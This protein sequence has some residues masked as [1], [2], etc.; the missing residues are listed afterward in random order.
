[1]AQLF[2][3]QDVPSSIETLLRASL[4]GLKK[5]GNKLPEKG[6]TIEGLTIDKKQFAA[7]CK[8]FGFEGSTV[9]SA[10]WYIRLFSLQSLLLAHPDAP[11]PMPGMVHLSCEI[12]QYD[13]I[14]PSDKLDATCKF[15]KLIQHDKG[16]AVEII[17]TL[18]RH[19]KVVWE[20]KNINLYMGKKGL[21]EPADEKP[22]IEITEADR[23]LPW[24]LGTNLGLEYAKVSGDYNPI[25]L[26]TLGAKVLGFP[27]HLIHGWYSLSR[28]IA[29]IQSS[30]KGAHELYVSFKK[31]LFLPGKVVSR[32][33]ETSDTIFFDVINETEGYPHLK[34]Y[35]KKG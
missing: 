26:H 31:P 8:M 9:P 28:A 16:T 27:K 19:D 32:T 34:G 22:A 3:L 29:P 21:G 10:Y 2:P 14:Y 5:P 11:F 25:H 24:S 35:V 18:K 12:K 17:V 30:M 13:T 4:T 15:G 20:E 23:T 6:Y 1:M 7:Y 33:Q